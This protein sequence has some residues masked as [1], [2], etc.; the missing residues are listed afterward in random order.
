[1]NLK[2]GIYQFDTGIRNIKVQVKSPLSLFK[3]SFLLD[4]LHKMHTN[5]RHCH[6]FIYKSPNPTLY[7]DYI[8]MYWY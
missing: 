6:I 8:Q 5:Y 4:T 3:H 2:I 1:M 7:L